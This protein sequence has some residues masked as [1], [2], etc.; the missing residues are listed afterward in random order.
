ME[1]G[2]P[3]EETKRLDEVKPE[4]QKT[5]A[6]KRKAAEEE[7]KLA[8]AEGQPSSGLEVQDAHQALLDDGQ[9][10]DLPDD[11]VSVIAGGEELKT[12][13]LGIPEFWKTPLG[14]RM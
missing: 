2:L 4:A 12:P 13:A 6:A 5:N 8:A 9:D 10:E 1:E 14:E 7:K 11:A 3:P